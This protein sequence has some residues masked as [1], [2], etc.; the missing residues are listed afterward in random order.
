MENQPYNNPLPPS[1]VTPLSPSDE[2]MW[3]LLAH[4]SSLAGFIIPFGNIIGPVVV[5]QIQKD[6]SA[7]VD[8]HGKESVNFQITMAIGYCI[9]FLLFF[10]FIGVPILI[11]LGLL[12]IIFAVLAG[13]KANNGEYY[14]YPFVIRFIK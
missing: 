6:K 11:I 10:I 7:F 3:G 8:Y 12:N 13:V 14:Q 9:S 4:L 1:S 5:W 2:R